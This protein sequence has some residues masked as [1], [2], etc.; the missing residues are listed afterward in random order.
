[1]NCAGGPTP[2]GSWLTCEE[3]VIGRDEVG[4]AHGWVFDV[5]ARARGLARPV[6]L[7]SL[8][9]FRHEAAAV[10]PAHGHRLSD[11]GS[12]GF[13]LFYRFVPERSGRLDGPGRLQALGL[14]DLRRGGHA[15]LDEPR[16]APRAAPAAVRW[17]DLDEP[18]SPADDLRA[19]GRA[20]GAAI[21]ARGEGIHRGDGEFYFCCTSGGAARAGQIMRYRPSPREGRPDEARSPGLLHL[22]VESADRMVLDYADNLTVAP[23]GHLIVCEDRGGSEHLPSQGRDGRG[24]DLRAGAAAAAIPS[25]PGRRFSPDGATLFVNIYE[26]GRTLAIT[27]P[28]RALRAA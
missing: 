23:W 19:R 26:P 4:Q 17:I 28:W 15:Q 11:R 14:R 9:R 25:W 22:F 6:P 5:P 12:G 1:M 21:F 18:E 3:S 27:G 16:H 13:S 8:G 10:D 2:W 7:R 24:A 20:A